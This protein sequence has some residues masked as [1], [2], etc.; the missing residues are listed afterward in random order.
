MANLAAADSM[1]ILASYLPANRREYGFTLIEIL[2]V[3]LI[4]ALVSGIVI[5]QAFKLIG[6]YRRHGQRG[7]IQQQFNQLPLRAY[8][9][10]RSYVL[11]DKHSPKLPKGWQ[12]KVS[13]PVNYALS[14]QCTAGKISLKSPLGEITT[15]AIAPPDC[16]LRVIAPG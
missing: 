12:L 8:I 15:Y 14:G 9:T 2:V 4:A 11:S 13:K 5:P 1:Q 16:K 3:L 6:T 7:L 10:G